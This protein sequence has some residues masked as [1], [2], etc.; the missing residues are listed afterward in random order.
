MHDKTPAALALRLKPAGNVAL[1]AGHLFC[2][3]SLAVWN[4]PRGA[5][6]M[7]ACDVVCV[8]RAMR[9]LLR[10]AEDASLRQGPAARVQLRLP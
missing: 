10:L 3:G 2:K 5:G 4:F 1:K 9:F 8:A 7:H 6:V